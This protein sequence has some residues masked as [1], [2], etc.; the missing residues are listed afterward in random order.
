MNPSTF[1]ASSSACPDCGAGTH[2][3][4]YVVRVCDKGCGWSADIKSR[5]VLAE[6]EARRQ[7]ECQAEW[8]QLPLAEKQRRGQLSSRAALALLPLLMLG[9]DL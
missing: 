1:S 9:S 8:D 2:L 3:G 4:R 5:K 6:W 7:A